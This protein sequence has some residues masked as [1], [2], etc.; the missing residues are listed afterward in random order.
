VADLLDLELLERDGE[1]EMAG[2]LA[3]EAAGSNGSLALVEGPAGVGKSSILRRTVALA[4]D[5]GFDSATA[6]ASELERDFAFGLVRQLFEPKLARLGSADRNEV[7][8]GAAG[9]AAPLFEQLDADALTPRGEASHATLHGLYWLTVNLA[10]KQ[11]LALSVDDL[12]WGDPPSLRFLAYL[13]NRVE[14]L[15]VLMVVGARPDEPGAE[16]D[17]LEQLAAAPSAH[18][19]RP[20]PLGRESV[21]ALVGAVLGDPAPE[22][23]AACY[24]AT[25]GNPLLLKEL[26]STLHAE[27]VEPTAGRAGVVLEMASRSVARAVA[28]RLRRLGPTA[29]RLAHAVSVLGDGTTLHTAARL[30]ELEPEQAAPAAEALERANILRSDTV[31]FVHP[32]VRAAIYSRLAPAERA[33]RHRSAAAI[34]ADLEADEDEVALHLIR[35][36]PAGDGWV[37]DTLRRAARRAHSRGAPDMAARYL[38]RAL[39]EPPAAVQRPD[40]LVDLGLAEL[41]V[42]ESGGLARLREALPLP[43]DPVARARVA[44]KYGRS[45]FMWV[46]YAGAAQVFEDALAQLPDDEEELRQQ[47]EGHLVSTCFIDPALRP[48][49]AERLLELLQDSSHVTDPVMLGTLA[50]TAVLLIGPQS[51]GL[52]LAERALA[53]GGLSFVEHPTVTAMAAFALMA[54]GRLRRAEQVWDRGVAEALSHGAM[55]TAGFALTVR[56]HTHMRIGAIAAAEADAGGALH[57]LPQDAS[58]Q[59]RWILAPLIDALVERGELAEAS[60]L[61]ESH[62]EIWPLPD[63]P[64]SLF[65]LL[66]IARL[67]AAQLRLDESEEHLRECGRRIDS[68]GLRNPGLVPWRAELAAVLATA[69]ERDEA[70]ELARE[71]VELGREFA[72]PR[73]LGMGLRAAGMAEGGEAGIGFLREGVEVLAASE[74]ELEHVRALVELGAALRREG[75]RNEARDT[76]RA[77]L[78][79]AQRIGATALATRAHEELVAA[80][81]RPRR[82]QISGVDALTASERRVSEM[83]SEGLSN[84]EIAQA[85]FVTEK[86]VE[87]HLGN[88]YRKLDIKSRS[89]L[90][91]AL[92]RRSG[93]AVP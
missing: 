26:V 71:A 5:R 65:L 68:W 54:G 31:E 8:A 39:T 1:L 93:E 73:E 34:L 17:L 21:T 40:I 9:L 48:R 76:L 72:V 28:L 92:I 43:T 62:E 36:R 50:T 67:R 45:L 18:L 13:A 85:L 37:V 29:E 89:E 22:F 64:E 60:R 80:G 14:E 84:R 87:S 75:Q 88:A 79:H 44:L 69:G 30:A 35:G 7:L 53:D 25:Q 82:L 81:A 11:P 63:V 78:D 10:T 58:A 3:E 61:V 56:A 46:D 2:R 49:V 83:A 12:H 23:A 90:P 41:A 55:Y 6:R 59:V 74:A 19:I 20:H 15:P 66:S 32:V 4:R 70:R 38:L 24:D 91:Q 51:Q 77:G 33:E 16:V 52:E 47:L 42:N 86:T 27:G 57:N